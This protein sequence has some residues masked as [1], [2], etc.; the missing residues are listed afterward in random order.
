M[1]DILS[2][3]HAINVTQYSQINIKKI[4]VKRNGKVSLYR[5]VRTN[6]SSIDVLTSEY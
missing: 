3:W 1:H 4:E 2:P 5:L 6:C